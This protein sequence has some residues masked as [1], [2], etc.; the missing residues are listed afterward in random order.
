MRINHHPPRRL[1]GQKGH[2]MKNWTIDEL[3]NEC[4]AVQRNPY[5]YDFSKM[6][7]GTCNGHTIKPCDWS[8][9]AVI[10]DG[11]IIN[12]GVINERYPKGS[13]EFVVAGQS[14]TGRE[15][16]RWILERNKK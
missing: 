13:V 2:D 4:E 7:E 11:S 6:Q 15:Y 3:L 8:L 12:M 1:R 9:A 14:M 5:T 10:I 16:I